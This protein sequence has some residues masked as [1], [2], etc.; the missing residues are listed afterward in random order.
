M[1]ELQSKFGDELAVLGF[2]CNQ[3]G[4][5]MPCKDFEVLP[6][7][8]FVRPGEGFAPNFQLFSGIEVNGANSHPFFKFLRMSLPTPSDDNGGQ[9]A[10]E[11]FSMGVPVQGGWSPVSRTDIAWNFEK[12]LINQDGVP[13]KRYSR[14]FKTVDIAEDIAAL[15]A[16]KNALS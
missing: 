10:D 4:K 8:E 15:I 14:R 1:N 11:L 9:G 13:V 3:F 7:L 2:S 12:F 16:D 5:Q 6:A